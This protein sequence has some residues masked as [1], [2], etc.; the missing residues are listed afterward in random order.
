MMQEQIIMYEGFSRG[1]GG[2]GGGLDFQKN[3]QNFDDLVQNFS[4]SPKAVFYPYFGKSL[5][6]RRQFFEKTVKKAVFG[7]FLKNFDKKIAFFW[8][9]LPLKVS[10]YWRQRRL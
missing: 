8:R 9:A 2:G 1:G 7:H 4:S 6:R 5:L 3:F 10:I